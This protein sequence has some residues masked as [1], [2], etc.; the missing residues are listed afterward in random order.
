MFKNIGET[1][2]M[3]INFIENKIGQCNA[4]VTGVITLAIVG[5]MFGIMS[6]IYSNISENITYSETSG[7]SDLDGLQIIQIAPIVL[8]AGLI[9]TIVIG[10]TGVI[11]GSGNS[12]ES[13]K[14]SEPAK[15]T[16]SKPTIQTP[17]R[18]IFDDTNNDKDFPFGD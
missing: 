6:M 17:T 4:V 9:I 16:K 13:E 18:T 8:A 7:T 1:N 10:F 3:K 12:S 11:L 5:I 2:N 15:T 14:Y